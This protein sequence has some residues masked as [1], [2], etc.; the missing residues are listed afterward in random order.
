MARK[1]KNNDETENME[2]NT[3]TA[4]TETQTNYGHAFVTPEPS[5][6]ESLDASEVEKEEPIVTPEPVDVTAILNEYAPKNEGGKRGR[7]KK[8]PEETPILSGDTVVALLDAGATSIVSVAET[9]LS[10]NP[11]DAQLIALSE[12]Q[13]A[14]LIPIAD[15]AMIEIQKKVDVSPVTAFIAAAVIMYGANYATVRAM[16]NMMNKH[17]KD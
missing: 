17:A 15:K 6:D 1:K 12:S 10:K 4:S 14:S 13:K 11:I 9:Y 5:D 16:T 2:V 8:E 3:E 7:K